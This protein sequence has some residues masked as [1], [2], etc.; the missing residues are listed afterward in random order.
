MPVEDAIIVTILPDD[1]QR[2]G[3]DSDYI[4]DARGLCVAEVRVENIRVGF[5]FHVLMSAAAGGTRAGGAQQL[6]R[7]H[8][9]VVIAPCNGE[10]FG[11][12]VSGNAGW[13]FIH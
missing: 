2:I 1:G 9:R 5:G 8:T 3:T 10:F 6:E 7:I 11:L 12:F 4:R 13:S